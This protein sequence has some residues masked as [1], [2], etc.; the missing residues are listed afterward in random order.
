MVTFL[1]ITHVHVHTQNNMYKVK[2]VSVT[3]K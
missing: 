1:D 2:N 3:L